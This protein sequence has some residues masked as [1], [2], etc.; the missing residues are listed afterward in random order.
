MERTRHLAKLAKL[1]S[2]IL[3]SRIPQ[4]FFPKRIGNLLWP[5]VHKRRQG[6]AGRC[7]VDE[8]NLLKGWGSREGRNGV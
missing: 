8:L 3:A 1:P 5:C 7:G 4:T 2:K 6:V